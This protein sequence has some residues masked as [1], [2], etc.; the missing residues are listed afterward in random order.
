MCHG[1][2]VLRVRQRYKYS[3]KRVKNGER[4]GCFRQLWRPISRDP[5]GRS[6]RYRAVSGLPRGGQEAP[7]LFS[8]VPS[9][10]NFAKIGRIL[11][12]SYILRRRDVVV[13]PAAAAAAAAAAYCCFGGVEG[14]QLFF[15]P[16]L[17]HRSYQHRGEANSRSPIHY[18]PKNSASSK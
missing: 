9:R 7:L 8:P 15:I 14:H 10:H 4:Q 1:K 6:G 17:D 16:I 2:V 5:S 12:S 11:N 13:V 3:E 18:V